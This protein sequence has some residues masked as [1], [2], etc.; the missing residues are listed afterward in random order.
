MR[1]IW[2]VASDLIYN[3]YFGLQSQKTDFWLNLGF[4]LVGNVQDPFLGLHV[5]LCDPK[6]SDIYIKCSPRMP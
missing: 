1:S 2:R 6:H 4:E 3:L 5:L